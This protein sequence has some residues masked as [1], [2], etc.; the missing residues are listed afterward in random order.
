MALVVFRCPVAKVEVQWVECEGLPQAGA[1]AIC[2]VLR[3]P[4]C[5]RLHFVDVR[6][7]DLLD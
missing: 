3:C 4:A 6:S 2:R 5:A 1:P 7:G